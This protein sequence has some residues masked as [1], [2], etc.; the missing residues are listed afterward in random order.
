MIN[1]VSMKELTDHRETGVTAETDLI[2]FV[3]STS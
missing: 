2:I 3:L 1:M